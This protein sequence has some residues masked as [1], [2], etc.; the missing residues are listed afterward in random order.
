MYRLLDIGSMYAHFY[1]ILAKLKNTR[2]KIQKFKGIL[3]KIDF[4]QSIYIIIQFK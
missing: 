3:D 2:S 4:T 1:S